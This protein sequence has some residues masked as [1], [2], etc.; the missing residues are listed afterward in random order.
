MARLISGRNGTARDEY[1][2]GVAQMAEYHSRVSDGPGVFGDVLAAVDRGDP[3]V[4]QHGFQIGRGRDQGPFALEPDGQVVPVQPVWADPDAV[5]R[6]VV[7]Y[8]RP[9][10]SLVRGAGA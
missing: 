10:G 4:V 3:V 6:G 7:D 2:A 1:R 9:D 8:R 5:I